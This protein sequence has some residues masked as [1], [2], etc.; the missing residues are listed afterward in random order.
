MLKKNNSLLLDLVRQGILTTF[1][2]TS[3]EKIT[4]MTF[5]LE[6]IREK[7]QE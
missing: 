5:I 3:Y 2:S 7:F 6:E 1:I 4:F